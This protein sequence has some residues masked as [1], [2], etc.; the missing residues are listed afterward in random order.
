MQ[1]N[2]SDSEDEE[3]NE[4][5]TEI[6]TQLTGEGP[7]SANVDITEFKTVVSSSPSLNV[8]IAHDNKSSSND[9]VVETK[10]EVP[11]V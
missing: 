7:K 4:V 11:K 5:K 1:K 2:E 9:S 10:S 6:N 8:T 3:P